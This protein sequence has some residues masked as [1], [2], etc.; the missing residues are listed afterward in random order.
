MVVLDTNILISAMLNGHGAPRRVLRHCL[1]GR[2]KPVIGNALF[3]EAESVLRRPEVFRNCPLTPDERDDL[4]KAYLSVCTY[5]DIHFLW[6]PNLRDEGDNHIVEL[7]IAASADTIITANLRDFQGAD[8]KMPGISIKT[9]Q[10][11]IERMENQK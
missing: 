5:Y 4:F 6:R 9:A 10:D 11:F 7:A 2:L 8:L 1:E 3:R